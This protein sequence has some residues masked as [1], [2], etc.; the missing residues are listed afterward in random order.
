MAKKNNENY[1]QP[2]YASDREEEFRLIYNHKGEDKK[3]RPCIIAKF[4]GEN[5][6]FT[7]TGKISKRVTDYI[8]PNYLID[9][10]I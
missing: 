6:V 3:V 2:K 1:H 8:F 7:K 4:D 5:G 10:N 9:R